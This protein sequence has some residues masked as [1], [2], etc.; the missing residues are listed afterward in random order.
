M[1]EK[2]VQGI[3]IGTVIAVLTATGGGIA[4]Y[5]GR[6]DAEHTFIVETS[7]DKRFSDN[8]EVTLELIEAR[9]KLYRTIMESRELTSDEQADYDYQIDRRR[10]LLKQKAEH[11]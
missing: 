7:A 9:L 6:Q 4:W 8:V 1:A 11:Q 3:A 5:D 10:I 2:N